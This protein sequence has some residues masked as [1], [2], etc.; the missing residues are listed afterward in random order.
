MILYNVRNVENI[1]KKDLV[2]NVRIKLVKG[3]DPT[4]VTKDDYIDGRPKRLQPKVYSQA[5]VEYANQSLREDELRLY[6]I[7][8][9]EMRELHKLE[10][11]EELIMLDMIVYDWLRI[12]R[13]QSLLMKEGDVI[14]L[15]L[16][17]GQIITKAHEASYLLNA[18]EVQIRN[19]MKELMLTRKEVIK[20]QI[21][22]GQKDFATFLS[23]NTI[24]A[25]YR[26]D[27]NDTKK[28]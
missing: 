15:K 23:E 1:I 26:V 16:R 6:N 10:K 17:S 5:L 3:K 11:P 2:V 18:I 28:K 14:Q 4:E 25:D 19:N 9:G 27:D 22:L 20:K 21:G 7:M 12:K 8:F 24:D 13:I